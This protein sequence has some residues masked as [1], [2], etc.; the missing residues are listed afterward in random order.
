MGYR[1]K[2]DEQNRAR[3]LPAQAWTLAEI[4]AEHGVAKSSVSLWVR[5]VRFAPKPRQR[6]SS[7]R[8]IGFTR[9]NSPR[10]TR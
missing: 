1:G 6:R 8:R 2:V 4:A 3:D 7:R 10:S 9:P 5:D